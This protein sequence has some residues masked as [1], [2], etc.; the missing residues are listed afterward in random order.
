[1]RKMP[2]EKKEKEKKK[3][4]LRFRNVRVDESQLM[5]SLDQSPWVFSSAIVMR[6]YRKNLMQRKLI[7]QV[8]ERLL[9]I[10]QP[11]VEASR[12]CRGKGASDNRAQ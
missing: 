8:L 5:R 12:R 1:M 3:E 11:K 9:I 2:E 10:T 4:D 7:G 6:S